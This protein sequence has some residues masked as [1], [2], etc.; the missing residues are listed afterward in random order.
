MKIPNEC[1]HVMQFLETEDFTMALK[2]RQQQL[3]G[4]LNVFKIW[5]DLKQTNKT[6][7]L[8]TKTQTH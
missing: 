2:H 4:D 3:H 1:I 7:N 6:P 8:R 5:I